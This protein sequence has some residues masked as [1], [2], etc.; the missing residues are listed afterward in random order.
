MNAIK[1]HLTEESTKLLEG[2]LEKSAV[3]RVNS[4]P[5]EAGSADVGVME[6]KRDGLRAKWLFDRYGIYNSLEQ[7]NSFP[8]RIQEYIYHGDFLHS[9]R[10]RIN[11]IHEMISCDMDSFMPVHY[12]IRPR[13]Q[14]LDKKIELSLSDEESVS[15]FYWVTHPGQTRAQASTFLQSELKNVL[16]YINKKYLDNITII[17]KRMKRIESPEEFLQS[18]S[19]DFSIP[20]EKKDWTDIYFDF[21]LPWHEGGLKQHDTN[22]T[23]IAKCNNIKSKDGKESFHPTHKYSVSSFIEMDKFWRILFFS[24]LNVYTTLG[25]EAKFKFSEELYKV[26]QIATGQKDARG[27]EVG[28]FMYT[29]GY[30]DYEQME[31]KNYFGELTNFDRLGSITQTYFTETEKQ[32]YKNLLDEY[33]NFKVSNTKLNFNLIHS[34]EKSF[35]EY[36]KANAFSGITI[37]VNKPMKGR[38]LAELLFCIPNNYTLSRSEDNKIAVINCQHGFWKG[39]E[40]YKEYI[41]SNKFF[42]D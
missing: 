29:M 11:I 9:L 24:S 14:Y 6:P 17:D 26:A 25:K 15:R 38:T 18:Y 10:Q 36:V 1:K 33:K 27:L 40:E 12:S 23:S 8:R 13:D 19:P 16:I 37:V 5:L 34:K 7:Y 35:K 20:I 42:N 22:Y 41:F 32:Y 31:S 4:M 39:E 3:F 2:L 21:Y 30:A 28:N